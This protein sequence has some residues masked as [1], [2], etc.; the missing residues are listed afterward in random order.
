M[1]CYDHKIHEHQSILWERKVATIMFSDHYSLFLLKSD[2]C[3]NYKRVI[4][5]IQIQRTNFYFF[6]QL[7]E[8]PKISVTGVI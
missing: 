3:L 2:V 8:E 5:S 4:R 6:F 1:L 7:R